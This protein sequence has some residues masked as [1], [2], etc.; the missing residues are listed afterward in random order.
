MTAVRCPV[1]GH[2][3]TKESTDAFPFCSVRCRQIDLGRWLDEAY[4]LPAE[5]DEEP[6][7]FP[8]VEEL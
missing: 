7:E 2:L 5:S 3:F 1:C 8:E 6:D 4:G